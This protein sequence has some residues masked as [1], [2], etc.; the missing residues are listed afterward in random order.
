M[1]T[2]TGKAPGAAGTVEGVHSS[3]LKSVKAQQLGEDLVVRVSLTD[4]ARA[5]KLETRSRQSFDPIRGLHTFALDLV[6]PDDGAT[7]VQRAQAALKAIQPGMSGCSVEF[8]AA[9]REQLEPVGAGARARAD[10]RLHA[11]PTC[12]PP[13]SASASCLP[14]AR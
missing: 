9:L 8:D 1:L 13:S 3:I 12:G 5:R 6:A 7:P 10:G 2:S 11:I 14:M 4:A